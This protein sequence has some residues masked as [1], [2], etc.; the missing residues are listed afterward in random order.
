MGERVSGSQVNMRAAV[1]MVSEAKILKKEKSSQ[2][3]ECPFCSAKVSPGRASGH[4]ASVHKLL[5]TN[6]M[7]AEHRRKKDMMARS[8]GPFLV[9]RT[10]TVQKG[11][12]VCSNCEANVAGTTR[13]AKSNQGPVLI[14]ASCKQK[15]LSR[16]GLL[17]RKKAYK[18]RGKSDAMYRATTGGRFETNRR[19]F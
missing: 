6:K 3:L 4:I 16:S 1:S 11:L 17:V 5:V 13:Y 7:I 18:P 19:K 15:V 9:S 10:G 14:C 12:Q 8:G 2:L